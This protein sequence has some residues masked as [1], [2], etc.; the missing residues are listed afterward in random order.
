MTY[1]GDVTE[2]YGIGG[3]FQSL[4]DNNYKRCIKRMK[5]KGQN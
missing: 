1:V 5:K 3:A 4:V 2:K